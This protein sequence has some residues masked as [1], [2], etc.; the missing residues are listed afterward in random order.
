M[1]PLL[2][3]K[4]VFVQIVELRIYSL[5]I[6]GVCETIVCC[7]SSC[8]FGLICVCVC[9]CVCVCMCVCA[10][11]CVRVCVCISGDYNSTEMIG[12]KP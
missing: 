1:K 2:S 5:V 10:C 4:F 12:Q 6:T 9:V 11:V 7:L 8:L 3:F